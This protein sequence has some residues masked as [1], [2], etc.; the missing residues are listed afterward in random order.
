MVFGD[1]M[2]ATPA[3]P[4]YKISAPSPNLFLPEDSRFCVLLKFFVQI[5]KLPIEFEAFIS[6]YLKDLG[7]KYD[8]EVL[9]R[10][11]SDLWNGDPRL[12][13]YNYLCY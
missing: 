6:M 5:N 3:I 10:K 12:I 2:N 9:I 11:T 8:F 7:Y 1:K 4:E 13:S